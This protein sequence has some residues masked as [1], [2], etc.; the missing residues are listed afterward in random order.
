MGCF[1]VVRVGSVVAGVEVVGVVADVGEL[2]VC[3]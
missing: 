1:A 3:G 2:N